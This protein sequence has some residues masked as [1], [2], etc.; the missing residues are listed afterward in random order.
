[1]R[2]QTPGRSVTTVRLRIGNIVIVKG[3]FL[4]TL[5]G[6][7]P[8]GDTAQDRYAVWFSGTFVLESGSGRIAQVVRA[9]A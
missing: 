5:L 7:S 8:L 6:S 1:M 4:Q 2:P 9:H 3:L